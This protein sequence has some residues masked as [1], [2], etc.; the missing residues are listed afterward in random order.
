MKLV[1]ELLGYPYFITGKVEHG[2]KLGRTLGF[3]TL[4]IPI[5]PDKLMPP[6]GVYADRVRVEQKW[7]HAILNLGTKPT[8]TDSD[9]K[10][11]ESFLFEY[12]GDAYGKLVYI[13]FHEFI[14]S[15]QR[16]A[17]VESLKEQVD[18]DIA[19]G[20]QYFGL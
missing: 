17:D 20:R 14:R 2:K 12:D 8:V 6:N 19:W 13:E 18:K 10:L 7:Y 5:P 11:A 15:E 9:K 16:F 1:E 4:N 3:P